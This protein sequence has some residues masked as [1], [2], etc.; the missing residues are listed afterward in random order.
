MQTSIILDPYYGN[1]QRMYSDDSASLA[2]SHLSSHSLTIVIVQHLT[3]WCLNK[4]AFVIACEIYLYMS[5]MFC[6]YILY[7]VSGLEAYITINI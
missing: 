6:I 3:Y 4:P 7:S 2:V 1:A 5:H